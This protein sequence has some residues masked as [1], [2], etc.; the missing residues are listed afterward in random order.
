MTHKESIA[1]WII[2]G[3]LL[4]LSLWICALNARVFWMVVV[5]K[6]KAPSWIPLL[7]GTFGVFGLVVIPVELAHRLCWLPLL[8]D[9]GSLP[10]ILHSMIVHVSY[11]WRHREGK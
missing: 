10:G 2:G 1:S 7:G 5:R 3:V 9:Y 6:V 4:L 8:L 11:F